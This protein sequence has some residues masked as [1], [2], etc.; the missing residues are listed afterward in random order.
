M[1]GVRDLSIPA[2]KAGIRSRRDFRET[3][4]SQAG[5]PMAKQIALVTKNSS[6][7]MSEVLTERSSACSGCQTTHG[8]TTCLTSSKIKAK[9]NNPVG[10]RPGDVV[11]IHMA[12]RAVWQGALILYGFP[13]TGLILGAVTGAGIGG[14]QEV[15]DQSTA[16]VLTG[17]GGLLA[18][19][20]LAVVTGNSRYAKTH[21]VPT[22]T[23]I[24]TRAA[25][26]YDSSGTAPL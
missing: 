2:L 24:V 17:L 25:A 9:V 1:T 12:S 13:L 4:F 10:A 20:V 22:I 7:G 26:V 8:C 15:A 5:A 3:I 11:E 19:L 6:K 23:R 18:G 16:A 21:L 14:G